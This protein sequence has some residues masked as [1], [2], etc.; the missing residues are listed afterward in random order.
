IPAELKKALISLNRGRIRLV[1]RELE[2]HSE[3]MYALGHQFIYSF[4][5]I[6]GIYFGNHFID[7]NKELMAGLFYGVSMAMS[8][9]LIRSF[10]KNRTTK[11]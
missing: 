5:I 10:I 3:K 7:L 1:N 4:F 11:L 8:V 2:K 9:N 6:S